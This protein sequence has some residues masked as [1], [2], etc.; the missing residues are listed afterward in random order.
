[1]S[2]EATEIVQTGNNEALNQ[3]NNCGN[4]G[5]DVFKREEAEWTQFNNLWTGNQEKK[6]FLIA[7]RFLLFTTKQ[8]SFE[9]EEQVLQAE[10]DGTFTFACVDFE[11]LGEHSD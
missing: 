9:E 4:R 2:Q 11:M 1:M 7:P 6:E 3:D 10:E 8:E 5:G